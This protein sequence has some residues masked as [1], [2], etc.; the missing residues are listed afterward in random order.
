MQITVKTLNENAPAKPIRVATPH[1]IY[2][3]T[4]SICLL[5][6]DPQR[7]YKDLMVAQH[8]TQVKRV[9]GVSKLKG[10]FA[11]FEARRQLAGEHD[12]F[13]ADDRII[14]MLP[15]LL[16]KQWLEAKK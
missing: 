8:C 10:K 9:V 12:L 14:P 7:T 1:P 4:S 16:G 15:K 5:C 13:L 3:K 6:A 2:P 11:P